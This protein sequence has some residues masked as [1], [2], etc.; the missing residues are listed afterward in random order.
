MTNSKNKPPE[1]IKGDPDKLV[2]WFEQTQNAQSAME[3]TGGGDK[4]GGSSLV[5]ASKDELSRL[6]PQENGDEFIFDGKIDL[7]GFK[8]GRYYKNIK[9]IK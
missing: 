2:E 5:G 1:D 6:G 9:N 8:A 3:K 7:G 4:A